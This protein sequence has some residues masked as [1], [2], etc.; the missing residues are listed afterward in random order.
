MIGKNE[1]NKFKYLQNKLFIQSFFLVE[2]E[3]CKIHQLIIAETFQ[4]YY[5]PCLLVYIYMFVSI[6]IIMFAINES[7]YIV[8]DTCTAFS[9]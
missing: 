2:I 7:I 1:L 8:C 3:R 6:S 5:F 4:T 9:I